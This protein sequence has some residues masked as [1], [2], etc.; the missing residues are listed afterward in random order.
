M[1]TCTFQVP[2]EPGSPIRR[3]I[4]LLIDRPEKSNFQDETVP[5][6]ERFQDS[7]IPGALAFALSC[8]LTRVVLWGN[9]L[10]PKRE[11]QRRVSRGEIQHPILR[12]E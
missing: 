3:T 10:L 5:F 9:E 2:V 6:L 8:G 7:R 4:K 12:Q 1:L 11:Y